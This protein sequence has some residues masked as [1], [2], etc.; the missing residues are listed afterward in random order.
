LLLATT[1]SATAMMMMTTTR[2]VVYSLLL[3]GPFCVWQPVRADMFTAIVDLERLLSAERAVADDL[4]QFVDAQTKRLERLKKIADDFEY[5]S[6]DALADPER[7]LGNPVNAYLL[8]KRFTKDWETIVNN[9]IRT[10][11]AEE[12]LTRLKSK[13]CYFPDPDD[14]T[15]AAQALLRLQDTYALK[16]DSIASG[17]FLQGVSDSP[18]MTAEDCFILGNVAYNAGDYYHTIMWMTEALH[19][20]DKELK[21]TANK[22]VILDYLSYALY[23]QGNVLHALNY[24]NEWLLIEPDHVRAMSNKRYYEQLIAEEQVKKGLT[25]AEMASIPL[26]NE[27]PLD[28]WKRTDVF[29]NYERLCRGEKTMDYPLKHLLT[30]R[31]ARHHP[32]LYISPVKEEMVYIDPPMRMFHDILTKKQMAVVKALG[33]PLL[34]RSGVFQLAPTD[35]SH[36]D[37][38]ISKSAWLED[39]LD[40]VISRLSLKARVLTNLTLDTAEQWQVLNY[41]IG[42]HYETH[43]DFATK[44]ELSTFEQQQGNR[45]ATFICYISDVMA[46]GS[47]VFPEI[48]VQLVPKKGNCGLWY[49]LRRNG[50]G[51]FQTRHAACPVLAGYKWA[52]NKWFHER[53]QEFSRPCTSPTE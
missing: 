33:L 12:F 28:E 9:D 44:R 3:C 39:R 24:T 17:G 14:I 49:N 30:C 45:V 51:D 6:T 52:C 43:C 32:S 48:G 26:R 18:Q 23:M 46:G 31:Y 35:R 4:R 29:F 20:V 13:T 15:G 42:G 22:A 16:S 11:D 34:H 50:D 41:G 5:H 19:V 10:N 40:P 8:I 27:R 21:K 7:H 38:R 25:L 47:T 1:M 2:W 36:T 37:Y 53:G